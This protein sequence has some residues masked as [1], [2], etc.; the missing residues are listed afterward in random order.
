MIEKKVVV[1]LE[2]GLHARPATQFVKLASSFKSEITIEKEGKTAA[3]KSIMGVMA[4]AVAKGTE[5]LLKANG[6][7]ENEAVDALGRFLS[8]YGES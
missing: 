1:N 7:D 3:A 6:P 8:E 5:I 2:H 4:L